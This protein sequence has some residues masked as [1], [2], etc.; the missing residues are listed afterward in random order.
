MIPSSFLFLGHVSPEELADVLCLSDLHVYLSASFVLSWSLFGALACGCAVLASDVSPVREVITPGE[1]GL[2]EPLFD[3]ERLG[4]TALVILSDPGAVQPLRGAA[5]ER[6][7][8]RY[9][10]DTAIPSLRDFFERVSRGG[11]PH[12]QV[13]S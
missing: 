3:I 8:K 2:L 9:A 11:S 13:A 1:N 6:V 7:E 12:P 5:R 10:L 4:Q